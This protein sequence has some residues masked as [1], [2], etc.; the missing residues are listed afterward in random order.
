MKPSDLLPAWTRHCVFAQVHVSV[1]CPA[2]C[3]V[4]PR[5]REMDPQEEA[6]PLSAP[7]PCQEGLG[8]L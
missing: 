3:L 5:K 4:L 1:L 6:R 8:L 2:L 7:L